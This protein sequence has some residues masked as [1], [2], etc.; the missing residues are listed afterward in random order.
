[1]KKLIILLVVTTICGAAF[2]QDTSMGKMKD[3]SMNKMRHMM[4]DCVV[5]KDGKVKQWKGGQITMVTSPVMLTNGS[6]VASDGTVKMK[7][8]TTTMLK[9][10]QYI[11]MDG[12]IGTMK[13]HANKQMP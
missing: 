13:N 2:C 7:D 9:D 3:T 10:G 11:D 1:M 12:N 5:M 4:K 8:G 6:T